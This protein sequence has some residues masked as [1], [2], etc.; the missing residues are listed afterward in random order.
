[1]WRIAGILPDAEAVRREGGT[2][3]TSRMDMHRAASAVAAAALVQALSA[4]PAFS[5]ARLRVGSVPQ[6]PVLAAGGGEVLL[7]LTVGSDGVVT[8]VTPLRTTPPFADV[9]VAAVRKW[10]FSPAEVETDP[11]PGRPRSPRPRQQ[12]ASKVLAVGAFRPPALD[13]PTLGEEPKDVAQAS[14][15]VPFPLT[16][17]LP[18]YAL[19]A[20]SPGVVLV[21]VLVGPDGRVVE[22]VVVR[23]APPFDDLATAAAR[24]WTFRPARIRGRP[25]ATRAYI[26]F[27]FAEPVGAGRHD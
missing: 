14:E 11:E 16:T 23:S 18:Q 15:E 17:R 27:G 20:R 5:P 7:E 12:V 3:Y 26:V 4:P 2:R 25:V 19:M 13:G 10:Q 1:M 24:D 8:A 22:A 9:M 21:E 6:L